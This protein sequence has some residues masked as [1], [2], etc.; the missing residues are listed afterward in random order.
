MKRPLRKIFWIVG[1]I[2][3]AALVVWAFSPAPVPVDLARVTRG[4]MRVTVDEDGKTRVKDRYIV[5]APLGGQLRRIGLK[6]GDS[7]RAGQTLLAVIDPTPPSLLDVRAREEAQAR[8][9]AAEATLR[10]S[11]PVIARAEAQLAQAR[12]DFERFATAARRGAASADERDKAELAVRVRESELRSAEAARDVARFQLRQA[13]AALAQ[14]GVGAAT[15]PSPFEIFSPIDGRVF[16]VIEESQASVAPGTP[17]L[18]LGDV[19]HLEA[20][21]DV[22]SRDAVN[23]P[24]GATVLLERW[25]GEAPLLGRVRYVEPSGFT[26]ISALGVEEQRVNVIVDF[27]DPDQRLGDNYRVDARIIT[28]E[29]DDV[30]QVPTGALFREGTDWATFVVSGGRAALRIVD[31]GHLGDTAAEV[32]DGLEEG[33]VVIR[34]PSDKIRDGVRVMEP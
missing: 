21:I 29:S 16:R 34:H 25:G 10:Q 23:I 4:P 33:E 13:Q 5:S 12:I 15:Q 17:L 9:A 30:P 31:I 24:P 7:V 20:V 28:W 6:T 8:V 1:L 22:L 32:L 26:K 2:A 27:A 3:A 18:E 19:A 11:E 14:T